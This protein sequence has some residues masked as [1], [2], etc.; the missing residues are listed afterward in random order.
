VDGVEVDVG[1]DVTFGP[2]G[3]VELSS[4]VARVLAEEVVA[5]ES[6]DSAGKRVARDDLTAALRSRPIAV[7][8]D[9]LETR[10]SFEES[11]GW[12]MTPH[13]ALGGLR[14]VEAVDHGRVEE[15]LALIHTSFPPAT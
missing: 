11:H 9:E 10:T 3:E 1:R 8:L 15:V 2:W 14:P 5:G 12:V 6:V 4:A 13:S 7:V